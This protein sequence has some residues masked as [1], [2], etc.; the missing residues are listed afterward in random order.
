MRTAPYAKFAS[1]RHSE[2]IR[3]GQWRHWSLKF[4]VIPDEDAVAY[5]N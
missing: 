3:L 1:V 5:P 2:L 4:G